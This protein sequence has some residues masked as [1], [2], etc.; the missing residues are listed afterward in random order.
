MAEPGVR[1]EVRT[2]YAR[3][4]SEMSTA[5]D[6]STGSGA[7]PCCGPPPDGAA[8][9]CCGA[10]TA[11]EPAF[12]AALYSAAELRELPV[13]A[14]GA[15]LGCGNPVLVA[16][17]REGETVVDLGCGGGIDALL[18][19]RRV[20]AAGFVHGIDMTSEMLDLARRNAATAGVEN[21]DFLLGVIEDLPLPDGTVDVVVSNCVVNLSDD[22][23]A[24]LSE[25]YR[26]LRPGG[27]VA[28]SD[29]VAEDRLSPAE[30]AE[31][32]SRAGCVAGAL[33]RRELLDGLA[34]A[35]FVDTEVT[36]T[37]RIADGIHGAIVRAVRPE[38][39]D[40]A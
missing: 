14:V 22:A 16:E 1:D 19:A 39:L 32:G 35:G 7:S 18:A 31:R 17:L 34:D 30:R 36:F 24:V 9:S 26:V 20:G 15:S 8:G 11:T 13:A 40:R 12:G 4:A 29:V 38:L 27:R 28:L 21:I 33:S 5:Q 25:M 2:H 6:P 3:L 23:A 37:H 10:E